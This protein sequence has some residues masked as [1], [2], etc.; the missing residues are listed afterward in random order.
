MTNHP[1]QHQHHPGD[2][3]PLREH[4]DV[5]HEEK[6][7]WHRDWRV[8]AGAALMLLAMFGYLFS[9]DLSLWPGGDAQPPMPAAP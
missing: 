1:K 8:W 9:L 5:P 3:L 6:W 7:R 4:H 2:H